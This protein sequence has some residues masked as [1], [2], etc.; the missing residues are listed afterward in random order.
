M[1]MYDDPKVRQRERPFGSGRGRYTERQ[2]KRAT[3]EWVTT[4]NSAVRN[5][6][7]IGSQVTMSENH[8]W[9]PPKGSGLRDVGGPF[10][11]TLAVG[12][13]PTVN[14]SHSWTDTLGSGT[15]D[16]REQNI[17]YS[18]GCP[19]QTSGGKPIWPTPNSSSES[20]LRSAGA[21]AIS[22]CKPTSSTVEA[23]TAV[24][25]L[26]KEGLPYLPMSGTWRP[27]TQRALNAGSE[28]LNVEFGWQPLVD[29]ITGFSNLVSKS[30]SILN[31]YEQDKGQVIRREYGFPYEEHTGWPTTIGNVAPYG[32][33]PSVGGGPGVTQNGVWQKWSSTTRRRWFSGAFVYGLPSSIA[34]SGSIPDLAAKADKLLGLSL[35]PD[36]LWNLT[37]WS[38]AIDWFT[39]TGDVLSN[40]G[41]MMSQGLSM[42]YG[43]L[44]EQ[45]TSR[46]TYSLKGAIINGKPVNVPDSYVEVTTKTRVKASPFGFGVTWDGFS[47]YQ[48]SILAALGISRS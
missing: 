26:V 45:T 44:M 9:P 17:H 21:T 35:T 14:W 3:G 41:D 33:N 11:T 18:L 31:Q 16:R 4:S 38:W 23:S 25:E 43:Y 1:A 42:K 8:D 2:R 28:Y 12:V 40:V 13:I 29:E 10:M 48:A 27:R 37:P 20:S 47:P 19:I 5:P 46:T 24:G 7:Y 32:A 6:T 39:N 30:G 34:G 15:Y 36:V 22:R